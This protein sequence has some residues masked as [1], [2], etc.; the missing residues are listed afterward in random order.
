[1]IWIDFVLL[2]YASY[3]ACRNRCEWPFQGESL[4]LAFLLALAL[5]SLVL[6]FFNTFRS[7][8]DYY[9]SNGS[10]CFAFDIGFV[11]SCEPK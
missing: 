3:R 5:K 11:S 9:H 2:W 10:E 7:A 4:A 1:M 8:A 6:F